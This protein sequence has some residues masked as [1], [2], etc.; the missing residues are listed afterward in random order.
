MIRVV[1]KWKLIKTVTQSEKGT[2][3]RLYVFIKKTK[4]NKK[5]A[6]SKNKKKQK[7]KKKISLLGEMQDNSA[8]RWRVLSIYADM[9]R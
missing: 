1:T 5:K 8:D 6:T 4:Q 2:R 3:H 7:N 9:K